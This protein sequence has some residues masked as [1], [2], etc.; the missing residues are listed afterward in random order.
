MVMDVEWIAV[1]W[2]T[3]NLRAWL[4]AGDGEV[5]ATCRSELGMSRLRPEEFEAALMETV[6]D[7]LRSNGQI[8]VIVCGMAGAREGW[9]EAPY[10]AVPCAPPGLSEA[11]TPQTRDVR[12]QTFIIPG[13]KQLEPADV[14][15]G[16]ETQISGFLAGQPDFEGVICLPGTHTKWV[17]VSDRTITEFHTHMTGEIFS[18]LSSQSVLRHSLGGEGWDQD[19]FIEA[20]ETVIEDPTRISSRLFSIRAKALLN[21]TEDAYLRSELS[22]YLLGLELGGVG[23][24]WLDQETVLIGDS[25]LVELYRAGLKIL[26]INAI[27]VEDKDITLSGLRHAYAELVR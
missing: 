27:I 21:N 6:E 5:L 18:L 23:R 1:D 12:L 11:V 20:L 10:S 7:A 9:K 24:K 15:R 14:M 25:R 17:R 3:T 22:G 8:P 4:I 16:E 13:L 26:G 2:G 19:A